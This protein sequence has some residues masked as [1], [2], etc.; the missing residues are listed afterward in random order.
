VDQDHR[1][2]MAPCLSVKALRHAKILA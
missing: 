1:V 2:A